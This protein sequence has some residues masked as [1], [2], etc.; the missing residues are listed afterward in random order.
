MSQHHRD[1]NKNIIFQCTTEAAE[2]SRIVGGCCN[3]TFNQNV[4]EVAVPFYTWTSNVGGLQFYHILIN[5][6]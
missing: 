2:Y 6:C 1:E 4:S 5:T 3:S